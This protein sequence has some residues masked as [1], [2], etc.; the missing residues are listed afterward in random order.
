MDSALCLSTSLQRYK[1]PVICARGE[2]EIPPPLYPPPP[3]AGEG[4]RGVGAHSLAYLR[5]CS[6]DAP[7]DQY[8]GYSYAPHTPHNHPSAI[9][10]WTV[11]EGYASLSPLVS[12]SVGAQPR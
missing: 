8:Q 7:Q 9:A 2:A 1:F 3:L 5:A 4:G 11:V 10:E 12:A 6:A